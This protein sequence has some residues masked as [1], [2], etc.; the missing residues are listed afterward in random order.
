MGDRVG[1]S[2]VF[3]WKEQNS[4]LKLFSNFMLT[5]CVRFTFTQHPL[6]I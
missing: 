3:N 2:L 1:L 4:F 5:Q 6:Q